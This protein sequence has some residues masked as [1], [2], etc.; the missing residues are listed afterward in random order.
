MNIF[1]Q[2]VRG[3]ILGVFAGIIGIMLGF[4]ILHIIRKIL[5]FLKYALSTP[6][7]IE[8]HDPNKEYVFCPKLLF[9]WLSV[10]KRELY[11]IDELID[12][13]YIYFDEEKTSSKDSIK[14]KYTVKSKFFGN[15]TNNESWDNTYI[16]HVLRDGRVVAIGFCNGDPEK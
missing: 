1:E 16:I 3:F 13:L 15:D 10:E 6:S 7:L 14:H 12:V 11:L 5:K 9:R 8:Y 2:I 4:C